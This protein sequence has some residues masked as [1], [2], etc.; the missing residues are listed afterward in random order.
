MNCICPSFTDTE[1]VLPLIGHGLSGEK[2]LR[3][4]DYVLELGLIRYLRTLVFNR[5]AHCKLLLV[6][7]QLA[8]V[9]IVLI[10]YTLS[11][12]IYILCISNTWLLGMPTK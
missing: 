2:N 5:F 6:S 1:M 8:N 9:F 12:Y 10:F 3:Y 7:D 11:I 4:R